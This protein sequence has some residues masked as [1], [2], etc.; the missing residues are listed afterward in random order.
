MNRAM[1][2]IYNFFLEGRIH[3]MR[4]E[5]ELHTY[6]LSIIIKRPPPI[7]LFNITYILAPEEPPLA[8]SE[9]NSWSI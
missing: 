2:N 3:R 5:K 7:P 4:L 8:E 1:K 9:R 6:D